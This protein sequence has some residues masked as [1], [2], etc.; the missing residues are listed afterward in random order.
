VRWRGE[1]AWRG[2]GCSSSPDDFDEYGA[3]VDDER[4]EIAPHRLR[5]SRS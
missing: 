3:D 2:G 5:I 1:V 4:D